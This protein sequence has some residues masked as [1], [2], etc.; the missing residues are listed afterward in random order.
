MTAPVTITESQRSGIVD[1][2]TDPL[3]DGASD[4]EVADTF[5]VPPAVVR[6]LRAEHH[7]SLEVAAI[8]HRAEDLAERIAWTGT[9]AELVAWCVETAYARF[10]ARGFAHTDPRM[11]ELREALRE[12]PKLE[13]LEAMPEPEVDHAAA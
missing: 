8:L 13:A 10:E 1:T 4:H 2:F 7:R 9:T 12:A 11:R 5:R 6:A 3:W